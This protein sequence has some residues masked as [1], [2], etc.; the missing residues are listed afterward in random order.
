LRSGQVIGLAYNL[1]N[2]RRTSARPEPIKDWSLINLKENLTKMGAKV[3]NHGR[4]I[5]PQM[6]PS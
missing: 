1:G 2:F 5:A 6:A 4:H 3:V